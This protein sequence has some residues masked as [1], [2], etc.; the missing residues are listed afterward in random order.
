MSCTLSQSLTNSC[1][2]NRLML[3]GIKENISLFK[4]SETKFNSKEGLDS[5]VIDELYSPVR[6]NLDISNLDYELGVSEGFYTHKLE[7][8]IYNIDSEIQKALYSTE[9]DRYIVVF[10]PKGENYRGFGFYLGATLRYSQDI[11][12]DENSYTITLEETSPYSLHEL[13]YDIFND[14]KKYKPIYKPSLPIC[15]LEGGK[16][17]GFVRWNGFLKYNSFDQPLDINNNL[18]SWSGNKQAGYFYINYYRPEEIY[19]V[20][21]LYDSTLII[22]GLD[23]NTTEFNPTICTVEIDTNFIVEPELINID[24]TENLSWNFTVESDNNWTILDKENIK[25]CTISDYFGYPGKTTV[26]VS[27]GKGG[28]DILRV[29]N[30]NTGQIKTVQVNSYVVNIPF[31]RRTL[32]SS[33]LNFSIPINVFGGSEDFIYECDLP[34]SLLYLEKR[35]GVLYGYLPQGSF[36]EDTIAS[37]KI[38]HRDW[39][40]EH[41]EIAITFLKPMDNEPMWE[42]VGQYCEIE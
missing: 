25:F 5:L 40:D 21:G 15:V 6:Y 18:I 28:T 36:N 7:G 19:D 31:Y 16:N 10:K 13:E 33:E 37:I 27:E 23:Y 38:T 26:E 11:N 42:I 14:S 30:I 35:D 8:K 34:T 41:K 3:G 2:N 12:S 1:R 4:I 20:V 17:N 29:Q 22:D 24:T 9:N 32:G 39:S